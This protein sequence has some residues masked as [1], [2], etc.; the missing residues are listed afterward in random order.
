M[1]IHTGYMHLNSKDIYLFTFIINMCIVWVILSYL[2][3]AY[4]TSH[5]LLSIFK[6]K[7][8]S[9]KSSCFG[10]NNNYGALI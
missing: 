5:Q 2:Y 3:L 6:Y 9:G 7:M 1:R 8:A 4:E 10:P